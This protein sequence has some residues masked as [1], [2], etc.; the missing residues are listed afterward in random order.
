MLFPTA[1]LLL[2]VN[3]SAERPEEDTG[4]MELWSRG[5]FDLE[6]AS[7]LWQ[8]QSPVRAARR[9]AWLELRGGATTTSKL[10]D[11]ESQLGPEFAAAIEANNRDHAEDCKKSCEMFYC[12]EPG[13]PLQP[14][15]ELLEGDATTIK[16]YSLGAVPPEDFADEFGFP[17]DIIKV[18]EQKPL[19]SKEEAADVIVAAEAEGVDKN[20]FKSGKYQLGGDWVEN[21]PATLVWFNKRL[22]STFFPLL[23]HLFPEI[24]SSTSV[25]RAHSVSL[26][27]YNSSHPRTD[28][29]IDNGIFAMTIAMTP[30]EQYVGG[31]T[32]FEHMG[33]DH[34]L[35]MDVGHGTFRPGS[36]RHGGHRVTSGD[37]YILGAFLLLE[38]KVEHVRRLKNRGSDLRKQG[39]LEGAAKHFEWALALNPKCCTCLKDLAEIF[40]V[41]KKFTQAEEKL[42]EALFYLEEKDSDALF[43]LGVVLSEQGRDDE[44]IEVYQRSIS[45]NAED[46]ELCYNLG[47]KMGEKGNTEDEVKYYAMA[48]KADPNFGGAW[49]NWGI[50][51]AEQNDLDTAE[52]MFLKAITCG[53][54]VAPKAMINLILS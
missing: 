13:S 21:L 2:L 41:Q 25:L 16:S 50:A 33:V 54:E 28:V 29:H 1:L 17:L 44:A 12:A 4:K 3:V 36:V 8:K 51:V 43:N 10:A 7:L 5:A 27:K 31:G 32:F 24:I 22:E 37:R 34:V 45:L 20:E 39:D 23:V 40:Q 18:T 49:L 47:V 11:L 19:F 6:D 46:A 38:D 9:N 15:E 52:T 48:T 26:L 35:P 42:R 53:G 14:L 30:A